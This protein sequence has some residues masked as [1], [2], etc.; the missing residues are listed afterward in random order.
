MSKA[1]NDRLYLYGL[2]CMFLKLTMRLPSSYVRKLVL[3]FFGA[4]IEKGGNIYGSV[5]VRSPKNLKI[6][7]YSVIGERVLLDSRKGLIIGSNV[8]IS[9]EAMIWTL[10]H[11]INSPTFEAV[12]KNVVIDDYAWI[13]ARAIILPGVKIGK[14]AIVGAGCVASKDVGQY[15]VVVGNPQR[16]VGH[17]SQNLNYKLDKNIPFL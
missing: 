13:C 3:K 12:G 4:H 7:K 9:T 10:H 8:N 11:D 5:E 1:I 16:V 14:G 17:R 6:G 15:E 2:K